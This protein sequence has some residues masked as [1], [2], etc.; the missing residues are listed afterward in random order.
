[1]GP[2]LPGAAIV[3]SLL[4]QNCDGVQGKEPDDALRGLQV[5]VL[6]ATAPIAPL[7]KASSPLVPSAPP[8]TV[9]TSVPEVAPNAP[10]AIQSD[11]GLGKKKS[12]RKSAKK[13]LPKEPEVDCQTIKD[14]T[15]AAEKRGDWSTLYLRAGSSCWADDPKSLEF[16]VL[17]KKEL[18]DFADCIKL[19]KGSLAPKITKWVK[20]CETRQLMKLTD[21]GSN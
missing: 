9:A 5:P 16:R 8:M 18:G 12:E 17:A 6:E 15:L 19:G 4:F 13:N 14:E 11:D 3:G 7:V 10:A 1:M 21:N 2:W 20:L